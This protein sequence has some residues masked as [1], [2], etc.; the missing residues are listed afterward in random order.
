MHRTGGISKLHPTAISPRPSVIAAY[1]G[2]I[3]LGQIGY[4]LLLVMARKPETKVWTSFGTIEPSE[5]YP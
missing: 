1:V 3:Y 2:A 4:C 5:A